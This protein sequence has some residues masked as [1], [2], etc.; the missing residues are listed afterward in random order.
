MGTVSVGLDV[1]T[2]LVILALSFSQR[3]LPLWAIR[4]QLPLVGIFAAPDK[5]VVAVLGDGAFAMH[6]LEVHT[7]VEYD[8]PIIYIVINNG[9]HGMVY[10]GEKLPTAN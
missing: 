4:S 7:A 1:F 10:N 6:G 2:K 9:A 5:P 3:T 8:L